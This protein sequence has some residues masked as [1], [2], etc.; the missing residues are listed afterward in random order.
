MRTRYSY[1]FLKQQQGIALV[2]CL[3]LLMVLTIISV[4]AMQSTILE[5]KMAG[6]VRDYELAFQSSETALR[7]GE[8][9][10]LSIALD[11][12]RSLPS[13]S[14]NGFGGV[15]S[16]EIDTETDDNIPW[17]DERDDNWWG[18]EAKTT[19]ETLSNVAEKGQYIIE[20][21]QFVKDDGLGVC[22]Y[23]GCSGRD[24]H[25]ITSRAEGGSTDTVVLLQSVFAWRYQ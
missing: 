23:D 20:F 12:N 14:D 13:P 16:S 18:A 22:T 15:W 10:M 6:N 21:Q 9:E 19:T 17:W 2:I 11:D 3:L 8:S 4:S 24:F 25:Q 1:P 5:E 7:S